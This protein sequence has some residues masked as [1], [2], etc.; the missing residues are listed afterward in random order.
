VLVFF[1]EEECSKRSPTTILRTEAFTVRRWNMLHP[2]SEPKQSYV[3]AV[4]EK[5]DGVFVAVSDY[6]KIVPDPIAPWAPAR[7]MFLGTEGFGRNDIRPRLRRFFE[8]D[9]R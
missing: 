5:K 2:T 6:M 8:V 9:G 1:F 3:K 7:L 4:F